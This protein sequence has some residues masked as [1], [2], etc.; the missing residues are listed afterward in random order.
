MNAMDKPDRVFNRLREVA[1]TED[2]SQVLMASA[3]LLLCAAG[4]LRL[5]EALVRE[6]FEAVVTTTYPSLQKLN[7]G[8]KQ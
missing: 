7:Q 1:E 2:A 3:V 5:S 4:N 8:V 6:F